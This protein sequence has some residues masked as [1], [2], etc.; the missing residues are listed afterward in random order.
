MTFESEGL[1]IVSIYIWLPPARYVV[2][3]T[4]P[5]MQRK[6]LQDCWWYS[7]A[8]YKGPWAF[9]FHKH[10]SSFCLPLRYWLEVWHYRN[11]YWCYLV[12]VSFCRLTL[13]GVEPDCV[14]CGQ[15][16][17]LISMGFERR[18]MLCN[19]LHWPCLIIIR[20]CFIFNR[21]VCIK[22]LMYKN[23][24]EHSIYSHSGCFQLQDKATLLTAER[25]KVGWHT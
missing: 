22:W 6:T 18:C 11:L 2:F 8:Q 3:L 12:Q 25:K 24:L 9:M 17:P 20:T 16:G 19:A 14:K 21:E 5:V 10:M 7:C 13:A 4:T 15:L 23:W 1:I